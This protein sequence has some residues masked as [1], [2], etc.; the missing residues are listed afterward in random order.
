MTPDG[1]A[2]DH[3]CVPQRFGARHRVG[4]HPVRRS[5]PPADRP[6]PPLSGR[7]RRGRPLAAAAGRPETAGSA[8]RPPGRPPARA[9]RRSRP[10]AV[11]RG[12]RLADPVTQVVGQPAPA[13]V[14]QHQQQIVLGL[15]VTVERLCRQA[16]LRAGCRVPAG[17]RSRR[18]T[19][20]DTS[21]RRAA[22]P[23]G[24]Q[25]HLGGQ[26]PRDRPVD[27]RAA[28]CRR[29]RDRLG[30]R[31]SATDPGVDLVAQAAR[32]AR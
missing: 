4:F 20:S 26:R 11:P 28:P 29:S 15:E 32:R 22:R 19:R 8:P 23:P 1:G 3:V 21:P 27:Q 13:V 16:R 6:A 2:V 25:R 10:A 17:R 12:A 5:P 30:G 18:A 7:A 9:S 14:E 31:H 24:W